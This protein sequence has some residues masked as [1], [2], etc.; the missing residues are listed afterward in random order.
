MLLSIA[1]DNQIQYSAA[2]SETVMELR[3][4][5]RTD[6]HQ[7]L[8]GLR[9]DVGPSAALSE[10]RDWLGNHVH[11]FSVLPPHD[12]LVIIA[13][14]GVDTHPQHPA[15]AE[16]REP[17]PVEVELAAM[18]F[19]QFGGLVPHDL[20]LADLVVRLGL[21]QCQSFGALLEQLARRLRDEIAYRKGVTTSGTTLTHALDEG[22][23]VCQDLAHIAIGLLRERGVPARYV[24]GYVYRDDGPD[25]LQTH[26][27]CEAWVP[28][29]GWVPIDP[30]HQRPAGEGHVAVGV[31]RD[32]SDVPPNRGVYHG[33]AEERIA[34]EVTMR[35]VAELPDDLVVPRTFPVVRGEGELAAKHE[36]RLDY[37]QEQQ[38]QQ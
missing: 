37:Q 3:M 20:R 29:S 14:S 13:Q 5:P 10:Y 33:T 35:R 22:A 36:E 31:G 27:W 16:L 7:S 30:T 26:A 25:E 8:R 28:S 6:R 4:T 38:Q 11:Q 18:H 17:V 32:Y 2:V 12:Q 19:L 23:G 24:S 9:I 1:H 15:L 21:D 34:V